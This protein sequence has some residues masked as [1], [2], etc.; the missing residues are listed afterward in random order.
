M[1]HLLF[2]IAALL[3]YTG[4][5]SQLTTHPL[6]DLHATPK[7]GIKLYSAEY[8]NAKQEGK[9]TVWMFNFDKGRNETVEYTIAGDTLLSIYLPGSISR[10][11]LGNDEI[12]ILSHESPLTKI[13]FTAPMLFLPATISYGDSLS[14]VFSMSGKYCQK[15]PLRGNGLR[16]VVCNTYGTIIENER[17]TIT[18]VLLI[19]C[20]DKADISTSLPD[21]PDT[22]AEDMQKIGETYIWLN[23]HTGLPIYKYDIT[24]YSDSTGTTS[25]AERTVRFKFITVDQT[26]KDNTLQNDDKK[27]N[28]IDRR[29]DNNT[30]DCNIV[31]EGDVITIYYNLQETADVAVALCDVAGISYFSDRR[32]CPAGDGYSVHINTSGLRRGSYV[33]YISVNGNTND[34]KINIDKP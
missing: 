26:E 12:S 22:I 23:Q 33:I 13:V 7:G 18:G 20:T 5:W 8:I 31:N 11:S 25:K 19:H 6:G 24:N 32:T 27:K 4:A 9:E 30:I 1:R 15:Y 14:A 3:H 28:N 17:D 21:Q 34:Y 2:T 16:T 29:G 10:L